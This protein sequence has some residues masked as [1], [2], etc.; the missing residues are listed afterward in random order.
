M[1]N[2]KPG[3]RWSMRGRAFESSIELVNNVY[4][5]RNIAL[6]KKVE[7]PSILLPNGSKRFTEKT[8]FDYQGCFVGSGRMICVEVKESKD[9]LYVDLSGKR[10]LR[11][12]QLN[13]IIRYGKAGCYTGVIWRHIME[14]KTFFLDYKFLEHFW[15]NIFDKKWLG[16]GRPVRS[17]RVDH[18]ECVCPVIAVDGEAPDYLR[19]LDSDRQLLFGIREAEGVTV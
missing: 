3:A 17:I 6:V 1:M 4:E 19:M 5:G 12:H 16:K 8:G 9:H 15:K 13:A 7:V 11:I 2:S 14:E 18:V 10:G